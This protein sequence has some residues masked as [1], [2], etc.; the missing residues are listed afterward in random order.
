[1]YWSDEGYLLSKNNFDENSIIVE[2]FTLNHGKYSGIVYGG[3]SRKQKRIFQIGNK[4][5]FHWKSKNENK[6]GYFNVELL[7]PISP[8]FFDDKKRSVCILAAT[9]ILKILLPERQIN[10]KIYSSFEIMLTNLKFDNWIKLYINWELSLIKELGYETLTKI[11]HEGN[12]RKAL[13]YNRNLLMENFIL[14][15][16]LKFPLFR[17]ILENYFI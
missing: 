8:F 4:I 17:N 2:A 5:L 6:L 11:N 10:K 13:K 12:D 14:P 3:S 15:N 1:M 9:S 7:K 16:R